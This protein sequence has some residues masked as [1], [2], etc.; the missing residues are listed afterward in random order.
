MNFVNITDYGYVFLCILHI[1]YTKEVTN[2]KI[3][4]KY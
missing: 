3:C 2:E 4:H 1:Y